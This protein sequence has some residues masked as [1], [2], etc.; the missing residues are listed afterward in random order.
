MN[1]VVTGAAG[2]I[3]YSIIFMIGNGDLGGE[4][5]INL[6][7]LDI[8]P[9]A[10]AL[11][12]VEM[13]ILDCSFPCVTGIKCSVDYEEAFTGADVAFLIGARPRGPGM[14]RSD[15]L[16]L[17]AA[18]FKGQGEA[19]DKYASKNIKVLVVGNPANTNA[20]I[21]M[22][23]AP[24]IARQNFCA[25]TRL[26]Q[27]R[28]ESQVALKCNGRSKDVKKV[29]IWG[30]HS[31]TMYADIANAT[32][33]GKAVPEMTDQEWIEKDF[34]PTIQKRGAAIITAR[35][36]SSAA[37]AA[38]AAVDHVKEWMFGTPE[39]KWS[40]MAVVSD[41]NPYGVPDDLIFS[42]PCICKDGKWKIVE[43]LSS[44]EFALSKIKA[45]IDELSEEKKMAFAEA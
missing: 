17:N 34:L 27:N 44:N 28:A 19:I 20:L 45:N 7:L 38:K 5:P 24:S 31:A 1:V 35:G 36:K 16:R 43:G 26:D 32:I 33:D 9:M 25:M 42:F 13:E 18:I 21:T 22:T 41:G 40:S 37:S 23:N 8:P 29:C 2:N 15:L 4:R 6:V 11:K 12:G 14:E 39:G 30:N 3:A 10:E